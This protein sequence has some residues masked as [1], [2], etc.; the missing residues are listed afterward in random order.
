VKSSVIVQRCSEAISDKLVFIDDF[1]VFKASSPSM[2]YSLR[3]LNCVQE[4][5]RDLAENVSPLQVS[6]G[7]PAKSAFL[8]WAR[9]WRSPE[10]PCA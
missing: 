9:L 10:V 2:R 4:I 3:R 6:S 8:L 7:S 1:F 5:G